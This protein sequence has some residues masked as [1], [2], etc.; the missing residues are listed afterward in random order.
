MLLFFSFLALGVTGAA[1]PEIAVGIAPG[2]DCPDAATVVRALGRVRGAPG[3]GAGAEYLLRLDRV[4]DDLRVNL[5]RGGELVLSRALGAPAQ[6]P[7][8]ESAADAAAI[9]IERYFRDLAWAPDVAVAS[10]RAPPPAARDG[11]GVAAGGGAVAAA[12]AATAHADRG[13]DRPPGGEQA[14]RLSPPPRLVLGA[15]PVLWSRPDFPVALGVDARARLWGPLTAGIGVFLPPFRQDE[16]LPI[17]G[18]RARLSGIPL[19]MRVA[20]EGMRGRFG[21]SVGIEGLLTFER[22]ESMSI[23]EPASEARALLAAGLGAGATM[24][25]GRRFR[26]ALDLAGYR[27]LLGRSYEVGGIRAPVLEPPSWQGVMA[28]RLGW[29]LLP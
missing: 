21:F 20:A 23:S 2:L 24:A 16:A 4:G 1:L 26:I 6:P 5:H 25:L 29:I 13:G 17:G 11:G 14:T 28:L 15:G 10:P 12:A 3:V 7:G 22:G 8:C 18:G 9:I 19:A 27:S